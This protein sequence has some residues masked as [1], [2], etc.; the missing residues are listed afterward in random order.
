MRCLSNF[1]L[2]LAQYYE[3]AQKE[4][5]LRASNPCLLFFGDIVWPLHYA[6][7]M[8][9]CVDSAVNFSF[10]PMKTFQ[11]FSIFSHPTFWHPE[12]SGPLER[13]SSHPPLAHFCLYLQLAVFLIFNVA[14]SAF[15]KRDVKRL[16]LA[17]SVVWYSFNIAHST[18]TKRGVNWLQLTLITLNHWNL[19]W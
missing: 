16:Q 19:K 18:F 10:Y 12:E 7:V 9:L 13:I 17:V 4:Q 15:A 6:P 5:P 3:W 14:R 11:K 2:L 1:L 8:K